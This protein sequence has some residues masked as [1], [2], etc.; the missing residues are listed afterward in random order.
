MAQLLEGTTDVDRWIV[1]GPPSSDREGARLFCL[2]YAG[3]GASVFRSWADA[4]PTLD[5]VALQLPGRENRIAEP[6]ISDMSL[7]VGPLA[8]AVA[9]LDDRPFAIFGH[10]MGARIAFELTR[11]LRRRGR[12]E[13]AALFVSA[14]K[15]PHIPRVPTP[16]IATIP[17][18]LFLGMLRRMN[19]TPPE[20]IEDPEFMR[21]VLPTLRADFSIIDTYEYADEPALGMPIRAFGGTFDPDVRE[22]DLLAWQVHTTADFRLRQLRGGHFIVRDCQAEIT[23]AI[24]EDVEQLVPGPSRP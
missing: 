22:D 11:E 15:A 1:S 20:L 5:V 18:R 19:G 14:C 21:S 23:R 8:D 17:D 7:A 10:S 9:A 24:A 6:P 16:P 4:L 3:G 13:P 12:P 2:S